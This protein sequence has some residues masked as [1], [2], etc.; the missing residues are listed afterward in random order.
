MLWPFTPSAV[1]IPTRSLFHGLTSPSCHL[2][3]SL[4]LRSL[5]PCEEEPPS[6]GS[7]CFMTPSLRR[8][9]AFRVSATMC[10][11]FCQP[12]CWI[13]GYVMV[14]RGFSLCYPDNKDHVKVTSVWNLKIVNIYWFFLNQ[15]LNLVVRILCIFKCFYLTVYMHFLITSYTF[16][17]IF[18]S[19]WLLL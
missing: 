18:Q 2:Q 15:S 10:I 6:C 17:I 1:W 13:S 19:I 7:V 9:L 11:V 4:Q 3:S 16:F 5:G 12:P 14:E 8:S